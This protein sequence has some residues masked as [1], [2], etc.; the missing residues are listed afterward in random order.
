MHFREKRNKKCPV[1]TALARQHLR[2]GD[3]THD[4]E[5]IAAKLEMAVGVAEDMTGRHI[6]GYEVVFDV[7]LP[8]GE[9]LVVLPTHTESVTGLFLSSGEAL[10]QEEYTFLSDDYSDLLVLD[11]K[12]GGTTLT[13]QGLIGYSEA[14]LPAAI[15]AAILLLLGTLYDNESDNVVGRSVSELSLTAER[16]LVPWRVTPY[17]DSHV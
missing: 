7:L 11:P 1:T 17:G 15:Q 10:A 16:L 6:S 13:V 8:L 3:A 4:D 9:S 14:S 12:Y 2:V 5:L